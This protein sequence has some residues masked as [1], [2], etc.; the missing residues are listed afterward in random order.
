MIIVVPIL[1]L[2]I[3]LVALF[4]E[5]VIMVVPPHMLLIVPLLIKLIFLV[6]IELL[7]ALG[8]IISIPLMSVTLSLRFLDM[9][10]VIVLPMAALAPL[11]VSEISLLAAIINIVF[12]IVLGPIISFLFDITFDFSF[13]EVILIPFR[14]WISTPSSLHRSIISVSGTRSIDKVIFWPIVG[15]IL[16]GL[17]APLLPLVLITPWLLLIL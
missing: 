8:T 14:I 5:I 9:E 17:I 11:P 12:P 16:I 2:I 6:L 10:I 3:F 7:R 13:L 15:L 1:F 4:L